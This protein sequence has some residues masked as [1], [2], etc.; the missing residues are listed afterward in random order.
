[1]AATETTGFNELNR[2]RL[3]ASDLDGTLLQKGSAEPSDEAFELIGDLVERGVIFLP[4]SGRQYASLRK[5]FAPIADELSYLCENGS[6][7]MFQDMPVVRRG[8]SRAFGLQVARSVSLESEAKLLV[9]GERHAYVLRREEE[10]ARRLR[11]DLGNDVELVDR[12]TD[13]DEPILKVAFKTSRVMQQTLRDRFD[14]EFGL[15]ANVMTSGTE[16]TD[17]VPKDVDKGIAL[18]DFG[19]LMGIAPQQMAAF[20]DNENDFG[21]LNLV[22]HPYLMRNCNPSMRGVVR[23]AATADTVEEEL[24]RLLDTPGCLA[25]A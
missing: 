16:W 18:L 1:M 4:A 2:I 23:G 12:L 13:I 8:F 21:M 9:S 5:L 6:L 10:F 17:I 25:R 11:E 24:R 14:D 3:I 7:V 22:G 20:G 19:R 15:W